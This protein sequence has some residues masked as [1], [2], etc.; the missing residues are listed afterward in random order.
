MKQFKEVV[1]GL[2]VTE[3]VHIVTDD[4]LKRLKIIL[5][6]TYQ[7]IITYC[8]KYGLTPMLIGGS[9]LGA[10]RHKGFIPWDDD[11]DFAITRKDFDVF[12]LHFD[13]ELGTKYILDGPNCSNKP[14]N[15]FPKVLVKNTRFV[16]I[17]VDPKDQR[18]LIKLDI[19]IIENVPEGKLHRKLK[20]LFCNCLMGIASAAQFYEDRNEQ[21]RKWICS[22]SDGKKYYYSHLV[23]GWVLARVPSPIWLNW[24]D[25]AVQYNKETSLMSIPT[26]RGHYFGEICPTNTFVPTVKGEFESLKVD[27]PGNVD[28]Y[29]SNLY[30]EN[31]MQLPP[32]EKRER[33]SI[34]DIKFEDGE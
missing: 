31:Y 3:N 18:A 34:I 14:S 29:L 6:G 19:F 2:P 8:N 33:H 24:V 11:F 17:G 5:L 1:N 30:G 12:K 32:P 9:A 10:R 21:F 16:E 25:K 20:G 15:R 22:T 13:E 26:G 27:L 4:E 28:D 7:D 23:L